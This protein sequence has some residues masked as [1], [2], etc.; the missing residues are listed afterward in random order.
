M[1]MV[2]WLP[3]IL[4]WYTF[5]I[6]VFG[7]FSPWTKE[8]CRIWSTVQFNTPPPPQTHTVCIY[9]TFSLERGEGGGG[10][11]ECRG[12]TVHKFLLPWGQQFTRPQSLLTGQLKEKPTYRVRCLYSSFVHGSRSVCRYFCCNAHLC[13][14]PWILCL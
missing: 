14:L 6:L 1:H 5:S 8:S 9:S 2:D 12:A 13:F 11:R 10:Q 4:T 7:L 3:T